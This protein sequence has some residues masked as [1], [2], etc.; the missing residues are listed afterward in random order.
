MSTFNNVNVNEDVSI[1]GM[2]TYGSLYEL[3]ENDNGLYLKYN[4]GILIQFGVVVY[5]ATAQTVQTQTISFPISFVDT[6]YK[7]FLT[8]TRNTNLVTKIGECNSSGN[9]ERQV[10]GCVTYV[11]KSTSNYS[12]TANWMCIGK[13]K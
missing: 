7:M 1:Q 8:P 13:W 4:N 5:E 3:Q 12:I 10:W 11:G 9:V 2:G 6:N